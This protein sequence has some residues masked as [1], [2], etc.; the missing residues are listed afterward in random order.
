MSTQ[1]RVEEIHQ[2]LKIT[3]TSNC[4]RVMLLLSCYC[5]CFFFN[6]VKILL[7]YDK[8]L[9][10]GQ[11]PLSCPSAYSESG[12]LIEV[13]MYLHFWTQVVWL[14]SVLDFVA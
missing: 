10:S 5:C 13:Q 9:L 2:V 3:N 8:P 7:I 1:K 14:F 6:K 11:P 12:Q 4:G